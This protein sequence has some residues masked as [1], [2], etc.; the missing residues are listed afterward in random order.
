MY[1]CSQCDKIFE[2]FQDKANHVRW[3]HI[4]MTD[5]KKNNLSEGTRKA[6]NARFGKYIEEKCACSKT[7]CINNVNIKYREGKRKGKYYCSQSCANSRGKMSD[8]NKKIISAKISERWKEGV[9]DNILANT[10]NKKFSSKNERLIVSHFKLNF[11][12][13]GWKSGG[14]LLHNGHRISRDLYSD[15]LKVCFEYDGIWHFK[16][17]NGQLENKKNKDEALELWCIENGYRLVRIQDEFFNNMDQI[18][19]LIYNK[20]DNIIKLGEKY[21][22]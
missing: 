13:D 20:K 8:D 3:Y 19:D 17:I 5:E 11:P 21:I 9:F 1:K 4:E 7:G 22:I 2:K 6:N 15:I 10:Q 12:M 14:M 18:Y 16:D